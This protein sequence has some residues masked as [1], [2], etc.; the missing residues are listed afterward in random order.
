MQSF[1]HRT[2]CVIYK[3]NCR[4]VAELWEGLISYTFLQHL[5]CHNLRLKELWT[6][7]MY[8]PIIYMHIHMAQLAAYRY[9]PKVCLY[10]CDQIKSILSV[11]KIEKENIRPI[12][13]A[14]WTT[15]HW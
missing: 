6:I 7:L 10:N 3:Y 8:R 14:R 4:I 1:E 11:L 2:A 9:R 5:T 13:I 15:I 12:T